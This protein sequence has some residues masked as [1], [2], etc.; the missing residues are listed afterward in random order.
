MNKNFYNS[1]SLK[2]NPFLGTGDQDTG[3]ENGEEVVELSPE[4]GEEV[5]NLSSDRGNE[6][7]DLSS[8]RG[9]EVVDLSSS[10]SSKPH[11]SISI[12]RSSL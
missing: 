3:E 1:S 10:S 12:S 2:L 7:F 6:L 9:D 8:E 5:V 4:N 11:T